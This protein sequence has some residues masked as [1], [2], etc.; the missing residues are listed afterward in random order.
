MAGQQAAKRRA[1][2]TKSTTTALRSGTSARTDRKASSSPVTGKREIRERTHTRLRAIVA[3]AT[4]LAASLVLAP[5]ATAPAFAATQ[6][7]ASGKFSIW[8]PDDWEVTFNGK[9]LSAENDEISVVAG[10]LADKAATL[11]DEDVR[12]FVGDELN[13]IKVTVDRL[14]KLEGFDI[15]V[16]EGTDED[17]NAFRSIA[18]LPR[19]GERVIQVLA[20]GDPAEM[21][22]PETRSIIDRIL[23]SLRPADSG[24]SRSGPPVR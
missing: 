16:L 24:P 23:Q 20:Y 5:I 21:D 11:N 9:R 8:V 12:D 19:A 13:N 6:V 1:A 15:R 2:M 7:N 4:L 17:E 10:P 22:K 14:D 18:L 3:S